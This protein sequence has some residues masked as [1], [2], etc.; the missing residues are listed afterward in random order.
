MVKP[1]A[2]NFSEVRVHEICHLKARIGSCY[3]G[4]AC[5]FWL[6]QAAIGIALRLYHAG[7]LVA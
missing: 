3:S 2:K 5:Y 1:D 4:V 6:D 7:I